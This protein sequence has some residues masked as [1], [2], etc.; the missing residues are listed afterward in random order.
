M[1]LTGEKILPLPQA[2]VWQAL[3]DPEVLRQSIP[4]CESFEAIPSGGYRATVASRIG[5]VQ[6]RFQGV[7]RLSE[8]DPPNGYTLSGEGSGGAA[9]SAKGSAKV[10]L[11]PAAGGT[12]LSW[13]ADAQIAGKLAQIGS[14]LVESTANMMAGQFFD[15]FEKILGGEEPPEKPIMVVPLWA[16]IAGG[17]VLAAMLLYL[18]L[19]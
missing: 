16:W 13:T 2:K 10:R 3:N 7:V 8:L 5:P 11:E 6:A 4:G 12:R 1:K 15:R 19:V 17:A 18:L 9:G 14:R